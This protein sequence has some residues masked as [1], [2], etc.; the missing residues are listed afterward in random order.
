[1]KNRAAGILL[2]VS[3]LPSNYGIGTMGKEA[4]NFIDKLVESKMKYWQILPLGPT[5]FGDSPYQSFSAF[6]GN[7]YF[8][9]LD[10][11]VEENLLS[12]SDLEDINWFDTEDCVSYELLWQNRFDVLRIAYDKKAH[13]NSLDYKKFIKSQKYWLDDYAI[14]MACKAHFDN[15]CWLEWD[16]DIKKRRVKAMKHYEK[17]LADDIDFYK[18]LQYKFFE[19]WYSLKNYA[20]DKNID[21]IGDI[22]I[23]V[24]M[25][26]ADIWAN[27]KLFLLDKNLNPKFIA[28]CPPDAFS[29]DGQ[30]WG[31][32]LYDWKA[33]EK[34]DFYWWRKRMHL[35]S[36]LYNVIR[37]DHFIGIE[38]YFSIP[39]DGM[40]K[41]GFYTEGPRNKLIHA[42]D[43]SIDDAQIIAEDLGVL[44]DGV[45]ELLKSSG[46]PGMK[47]LQFAF[48]SD[49]ENPYLPHNHIKNCILYIGTHDNDTISG[50]LSTISEQELKFLLKYL[51]CSDT[52]NIGD[53]L[54]CSAFASVSDTLILQMQD[55]LGKDSTSRMN[56]P[57]TTENNWCFRMRKDDFKD[58]HT[59]MLR[60]YSETY[61]RENKF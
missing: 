12:Q 25:D 2:H 26:S 40:A 1:M 5:S 39:I 48:G 49:A 37:I 15:K 23:Y 53:K 60:E 7:P 6:A 24:S 50:Y 14:F 36:K 47:V 16:E 42:I 38:R 3:S 17:L 58:V 56:F 45:R 10:F 54:I 4:F 9:D 8:I 21:I 52:E 27:S 28:G 61:G 55:I 44:T 29:E 41:D 46:Y 33:L 20:N 30:K 59:K 18:F 51:D 11:L 31:N 43:E 35:S 13:M 34:D 22:P 57:S 32:P 19:Q